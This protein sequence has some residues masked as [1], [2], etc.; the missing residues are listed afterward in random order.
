MPSDVGATPAWRPETCANGRQ[1]STPGVR[2]MTATRW[3][4]AMLFS[5]KAICPSIVRPFGAAGGG[6]DGATSASMSDG[7]AIVR[8]LT[9]PGRF[10]LRGHDAGGSGRR[11]DAGGLRA[12]SRDERA[13]EH[14]HLG[15]GRPLLRAR[16]GAHEVVRA[17]LA[18][19][20]PLHEGLR[21]V[22]ARGRP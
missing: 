1:M 21:R 6:T 5:P 2:P 7:T 18:G 16:R 19:G 10:E 17:H 8:L 15:D 14:R 20:D 22:R 13:E 3:P 4:V 12:S 9:A 11:H